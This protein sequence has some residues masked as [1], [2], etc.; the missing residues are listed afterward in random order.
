MD[1]IRAIP[2]DKNGSPVHTSQFDPVEGEY[3]YFEFDPFRKHYLRWIRLPK[4]GRRPMIELNRD[5]FAVAVYDTNFHLLGESLLPEDL[6]PD[7]RIGRWLRWFITPEGYYFRNNR[8]SDTLNDV[9]DAFD[10][11]FGPAKTDKQLKSQ[12]KIQEQDDSLA[13]YEE[14]W[15]RYL[16][17]VQGVERI[18]G[19]LLIVHTR[20]GCPNCRAHVLRQFHALRDSLPDRPLM[21]LLLDKSNAEL[22]GL[23]GGHPY[24]SEV[25]KTHHYYARET[26]N[27]RLLFY[28][29]GKLYRNYEL[30]PA[31]VG[32][33]PYLIDDYYK[34]KKLPLPGGL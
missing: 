30:N 29:K 1:A 3:C 33:V 8:T 5:R 14:D 24:Y 7:E 13:I 4:R 9:F 2:Y 26:G 18:D 27:P 19:P 17:E 25:N 20:R 12:P 31:D 32:L 10:L 23:I 34:G 28:K 22:D 11:Q 16:K 21:L 6:Q 15:A